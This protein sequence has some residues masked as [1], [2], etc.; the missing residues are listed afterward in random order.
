MSIKLND[1]NNFGS[2]QVILTPN[3]Q[4][5]IS[6]VGS[7]VTVTEVNTSQYTSWMKGKLE[8]NN[9]SLEIVMKRLARWYDF[10]YEFENANTKD[11][12]FTARIN[13]NESISTILNM[14]E[15]L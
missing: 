7:E 4:A 8:F 14:L 2:E 11:Y 3:K 9:E 1:E 5:I 12:H 10:E 15:K 6:K 13:N